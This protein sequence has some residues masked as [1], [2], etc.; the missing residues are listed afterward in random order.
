MQKRI[1]CK[2]PDSSSVCA[3][4]DLKFRNNPPTSKYCTIS[5]KPEIF[6]RSSKLH[7][8]LVLLAFGKLIDRP[9]FAMSNFGL[10]NF[11]ISKST[12]TTSTTNTNTTSLPVSATHKASHSD[13]K[14]GSQTHDSPSA[15]LQ[16]QTGSPNSSSNTGSVKNTA[17]PGGLTSTSLKAQEVAK[18]GEKIELLSIFEKFHLETAKN[19]E[20]NDLIQEKFEQFKGLEQPNRD[21]ETHNLQ[22]EHKHRRGS[23]EKLNQAIEEAPTTDITTEEGS[24]K[25]QLKDEAGRVETADHIAILGDVPAREKHVTGDSSVNTDAAD[26]QSMLIQ[27]YTVEDNTVGD[28]HNMRD[29]LESKPETEAELAQGLEVSPSVSA[30]DLF[31][32]KNAVSVEEVQIQ[33]PEGHLHR[34]KDSSDESETQRPSVQRKNSIVKATKLLVDAREQHQQSHRPFDFQIF[35]SQLRYKDA[36]PIVKYIRSFLMSFARQASSLSASQMMKAVQDFKKFIAE[37]FRMYEPFASMDDKDLENSVE[38]VEKLIMN[39]L[40]EFCFPPEAQ[41]RFTGRLQSALS[42]D[43]I[44]DA[45]LATQLEKFSW[46]LGVHLDVNLDGLSEKKRTSPG[47]EIDYME[48]AS[49]ELNKINKY[50]A[51]RDK[52]ICILNACKIL[53]SLLRVTDQETN[54]DAFIPLLILVILKAKTDNLISNLH[55]IE[56][57]R[58]ENWLNHGETSYYLSTM[59]GAIAFIQNIKREDLTIEQSHYDAHIE[60]WDAELRQRARED[61]MPT[62]QGHAASKAVLPPSRSG[63][64]PSNV[65]M[66]S[67]ELFSKSISNLIAPSDGTSSDASNGDSNSGDQ[68]GQTESMKA[69]VDETYAQ[70][71]EIFP[72]L[73]KSIMRDVIVM[74]QADFETSLEVCLQLV[75]DS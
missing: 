47:D 55:Y 27:P 2:I 22:I 8:S 64:L 58:G 20:D 35:L 34:A 24:L 36:E 65:L 18:S 54:A 62:G 33:I 53:F 1:T 9:V 4:Q 21:E 75:D 57:F 43:L 37:K 10:F 3:V 71:S 23:A 13:P 69:Q 56:R 41:T 63:M 29:V 67:A 60:A 12:P 70:L 40:Y 16:S 26:S 49:R 38:G 39:R 66:A 6:I 5:D 74:N 44:D 59:Q 48:Y 45:A 73:D 52:I 28:D 50:R 14:S 68:G 11:N 32:M 30:N 15:H 19:F 46:I 7:R 31:A 17:A 72:S 42:K 61:H 51:P 25:T